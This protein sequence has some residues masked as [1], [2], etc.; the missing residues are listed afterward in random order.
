MSARLAIIAG[1]GALARHVAAA[2]SEPPFVAALAGFAPDG[3]AVDLT[4]RVERLVPALRA[5]SEAGVGQ[6]VFAGG[7]ARPQ[8]DPAAFDPATAGLMPQL[9]PA[10]QAG[11]DAT[12]RAVI[13][14][15]EEFG[16]AVCGI[17]EAAPDLL[18]AKGVLGACA[19]SA[20]DMSDALRATE[21]LAAMSAADVGQGCVVA[22]GLCLG[23]EAIYGT[24]AM[25]A[26]VARHRPDLHPQ[27]GG[28]LM[29]RAKTGQDLRIDLPTIG[30]A[31]IA[32]AIS[33]GVSGI[34]VQA[35]RSLVIDRDAT[36]AAAD[37]AGLA[38]WAVD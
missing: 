32:A 33:A 24:D 27:R 3:L 11:D 4:I 9:L 5:L 31:T 21:I 29:K 37:A 18:A 14:L 16:L 36:V 28:I 22:G 25:L 20:M 1:R 17:A 10:L 12:L 6:V 2:Q 34:C 7:V 13:G 19:P 26:G 23:L 30:P 35:G 38:L 8:L 15:F